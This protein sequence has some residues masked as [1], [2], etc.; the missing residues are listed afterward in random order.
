MKST[1]LSVRNIVG[2]A[3]IPPTTGR[4]TGKPSLAYPSTMLLLRSC[5]DKSSQQHF[6]CLICNSGNRPSLFPLTPHLDLVDD[7]LNVRNILSQFCCSLP[8]G[9]GFHRTLQCQDPVS[10]AATNVLLA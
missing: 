9:W 7:L 3:G 1:W 10:C 8:L 2:T 6:A 4:L 5:N